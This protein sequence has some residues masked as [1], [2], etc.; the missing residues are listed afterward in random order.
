M[1]DSFRDGEIKGVIIRKLVKTGD[2]RGW[3]AELFR[4][5]ELEGVLRPWKHLLPIPVSLVTHEHRKHAD[6]F[7]FKVLPIQLRMWDSASQ[8]RLVV[9]DTRVVQ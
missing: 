2:S 6:L 1:S 8:R 5:D 3:L 7:C 4:E 9:D